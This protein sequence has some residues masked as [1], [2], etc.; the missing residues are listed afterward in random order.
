MCVYI[1]TVKD[2]VFIP[3]TPKW[4]A[5][6]RNAFLGTANRALCVSVSPTLADECNGKANFHPFNTV[7]R[8]FPL[9]TSREKC[10]WECKSDNTQM[11]SKSHS[12]AP[13]PAIGNFHSGFIFHPPFFWW[14][15]CF[16]R[17]PSWT[18]WVSKQSRIGVQ[19]GVRGMYEFHHREW[20]H[21]LN[22]P[23][24]NNG[25]LGVRCDG[26]RIFRPLPSVRVFVLFLVAFILHT[27]CL[28]VCW[29]LF[30]YS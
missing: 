6:K 15:G 18:G 8:L 30:F 19:G 1:S 4:S 27:E 2:R 3:Q 13:F 5:E 16:G 9:K 10:I 23:W 20:R 24:V 12:F 28:R 22:W 29:V 14:R 11:K 21:S 17:P 26:V 25:N 7:D